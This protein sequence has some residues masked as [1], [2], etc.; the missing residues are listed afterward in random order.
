VSGRAS[1]SSDRDCLVMHDGNASAG[2]AHI[3]ILLVPWCE[4]MVYSLE[5][6]EPILVRF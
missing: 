5:F 1:G 4:P 2:S 6:S 3:S